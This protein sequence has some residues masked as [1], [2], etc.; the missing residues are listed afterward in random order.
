MWLQ[1]L[2]GKWQVHKALTA[3]LTVY[4][5]VTN[6][7]LKKKK[8]EHKLV[9]IL[10]SWWNCN[11]GLVPLSFFVFHFS[12]NRFVSVGLVNRWAHHDIPY[13]SP[14]HKQDGSFSDPSDAAPGRPVRGRKEMEMSLYC[15]NLLHLHLSMFSTAF[16]ILKKLN[17]K[18]PVQLSQF[19]FQGSKV[20]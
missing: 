13:V 2:L 5:S 10:D 19:Q 7:W 12:L 15:F 17:F 16:N 3:S 4:C 1:Y 8:Q 6:L 18:P 20:F 9:V 11:A 14:L